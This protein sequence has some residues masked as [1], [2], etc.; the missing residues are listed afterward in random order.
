MRKKE[1]EE[2]GKRDRRRSNYRGGVYVLL[3]SRGLG[4]RIY[5]SNG[6][7]RSG[8]AM[9]LGPPLLNG[10]RRAHRPRGGLAPSVYRR[11]GKASRLFQEP[12]ARRGR[13]RRCRRCVMSSPP[14]AP[15]LILQLAN[16]HPHRRIG[17]IHRLQPKAP[18]PLRDSF[19]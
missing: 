11:N 13:R 14:R 6:A 17:H 10:N 4:R 5:P 19:T 18:L 9:G 2:E 12:G 15:H 16:L 3:I 1:E 8:F 7:W